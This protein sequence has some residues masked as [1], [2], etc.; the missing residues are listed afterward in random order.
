MSK[1]TDTSKLTD[2]LI[3]I[4]VG[5]LLVMVV[6]WMAFYIWIHIWMWAVGA[7]VV[8]GGVWLVSRWLRWRRDRW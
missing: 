5:L 3:E 1:H 2:M 4:A 7:L 8:V 6:L